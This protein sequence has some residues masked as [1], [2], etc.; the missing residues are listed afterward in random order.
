MNV[1]FFAK[2]TEEIM[3]WKREAR[4]V[5]FS[6][7]LSLASG[8]AQFLSYAVLARLLSGDEFSRLTI[9]FSFLPIYLSF[10]EM[11]LTGKAIRDLSE[12]LDTRFQFAKLVSSRFFAVLLSLAGLTLHL[13]FSNLS[14]ETN[15]CIVLLLTSLF[16]ASFLLSIDAFGYSRQNAWLAGASRWVRCLSF[17][18]MIAGLLLLFRLHK[19]ETN[20]VLWAAAIFVLTYTSSVFVFYRNYAKEIILGLHDFSLKQAFLNFKNSLPFGTLVFLQFFCNAIFSALLLRT[21]GELEV[22]PFNLANTLCVPFNLF[23]QVLANY[24]IA[25]SS[26]FKFD[27]KKILF[28]IISTAFIIIS[29]AFVLSHEK[30][31]SL[32]FGAQASPEI[33]V[34]FYPLLG[35]YTLAT[36]GGL[37]TLRIQLA[38][39]HTWAI[40][41]A[42]LPIIVLFGAWL[43]PI[44]VLKNIGPH[45]IF[46]V[47]NSVGF[48]FLLLAQLFLKISRKI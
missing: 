4:F 48:C 20:I 27:C 38:A 19:I 25:K 40:W 10:P 46:I 24:A 18:G 22:K 3:G 13:S 2:E 5:S 45:R 44:D 32:F 34:Y 12:N 37:L 16:P 11:G 33:V 41:G 7:V 6:Y 42:A 9:V 17:L 31:L 14:A 1:E 21:L 30:I 26:K 15:V 47:Q 36:L 28:G 35:A 23:A 8:G 29:Y 39:K 43:L